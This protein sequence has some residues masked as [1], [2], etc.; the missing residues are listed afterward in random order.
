MNLC[1][2]RAENRIDHSIEDTLGWAIK[3]VFLLVNVRRRERRRALFVQVRTIEQWLVHIVWRVSVILVLSRWN[4][5][6]FV[7]PSARVLKDDGTGRGEFQDN[8]DG[9][10]KRRKNYCQ[11]QCPDNKLF[12][13]AWRSISN[14]STH[15]EERE[16]EREISREDECKSNP[17]FSLDAFIG[18]FSCFS[19]SVLC[20]S[21]PRA[22]EIMCQT[23]VN[24]VCVLG[25][26]FL[27]LQITTTTSRRRTKEGRFIG[28]EKWINDQV[29]IAASV[30]GFCS[31]FCF[32]KNKDH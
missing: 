26:V 20:T 4:N 11:C 7:L 31:C 24:I 2:E 21:F 13:T 30:S 29:S 27:E 17:A 22:A 23:H 16:R 19:P 3:N 32:A 9:I 18:W 5:S 8:M 15:E 28:Q 1:H 6:A 10:D 12:M 14:A 25:L